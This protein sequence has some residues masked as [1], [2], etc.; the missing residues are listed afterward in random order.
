L[1]FLLVSSLSELHFWLL[2][3]YCCC[4]YVAEFYF[5]FECH[6]W[7]KGEGIETTDY[8]G[9]IVVIVV[10]FFFFA[11]EFRGSGFGN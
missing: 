1:L 5:L 9:A 3:Y 7:E 6:Q 8:R 2:Y 4:Y 11:L 10:V